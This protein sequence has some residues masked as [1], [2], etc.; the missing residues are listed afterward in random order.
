MDAPKKENRW[1][2]EK[3]TLV[4]RSP[5]LEVVERLC[6]SSEDRRL[7]PFYLMRSRD[8]CNIIPV[9]EDGK[10]VLVRQFRIGIDEHTLEIPGGIADPGDPTVQEA[11]LRELAEETGYVPLPGARCVSI[12]APHSNPAIFNNR[13]HSFIVGPVRRER[14]QALDSGEMIEVEEV[15]IGEIPDRIARGEITHVLMLN[16][17]MTLAFQAPEGA[18]ALKRQLERF[19]RLDLPMKE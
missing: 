5:V 1:H 15:P 2:C 17:F 9:T 13:V 14:D 19:S 10:I 16:A 4:L 6:R 8:W 18:G 12:C 3:E 11:A 7:H